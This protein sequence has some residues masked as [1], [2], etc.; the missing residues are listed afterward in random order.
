M[1]QLIS[2]E[3]DNTLVL[4]SHLR[5]SPNEVSSGITLQLKVILLSPKS[6]FPVEIEKVKIQ[7]GNLVILHYLIN[8]IMY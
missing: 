6:T 4:I 1:N 2:T 3:G 8:Y 7:E 5:Y